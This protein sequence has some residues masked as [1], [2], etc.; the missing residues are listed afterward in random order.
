M[1]LAVML[2]S[3]ADNLGVGRSAVAHIMFDTLSSVARTRLQASVTTDRL[4]IQWIP[5]N[6]A[7]LASVSMPVRAYDHISPVSYFRLLLPD[8]LPADLQRVIYLDCDLAVLGDIGMLWD[9]DLNDHYVAAVPELTTD[10]HLVSSPQGIRLWRELGLAADLEQFNSGVLLINLD[11]W[12]AEFVKQRALIYLEKAADWLRWHDQE[13]LNVVFAGAWLRLDARWNLTMRQLMKSAPVTYQSP[14][15]IHYHSAEKPWH[16]G[17]PFA[18]AD[19]FFDYLDRTAWSGWRPE[20][21]PFAPVRRFFK[22]FVKALHKRQHAFRRLS[23][24]R[25]GRLQGAQLL[26]SPLTLLG[27]PP[28]ANVGPGEIRVFMVAD[29]CTPVACALI[30]HYLASGA[31]RV[32]LAINASVADTWRSFADVNSQVHLVLQGTLSFDEI[33]RVML[34][35]YGQ[36]HWC[37]PA[38][39]NEWL[40]FPCDDQLTL[41][42]LT[43]HLDAQHCTALMSRRVE[44]LDASNAVVEDLTRCGTF[45]VSNEAVHKL[46]MTER[47]MISNRIFVANSYVVP[48]QLESAPYAA[49]RS[50]VSLVKYTSDM[51]IGPNFR[52]AQGIHV[53]DIEGVMLQG[54]TGAPSRIHWRALESAGLLRASEP[55]ARIAML[56][57]PPP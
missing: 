23:N 12:R 8:L 51:L 24:E 11:K 57:T 48:N 9:I 25:A 32:V 19:V 52:S 26:A 56:E 30:E 43:R 4:H 10:S 6:H 13:A 44:L 2:R 54:Q 40:R 33:L 17:Y 50:V 28:P 27:R 36:G 42:A 20:Y 7:G 16:A 31:D 5:V 49:F 37:L 39:P 14:C 22:R 38:R 47:D 53:S 15:I 46:P 29:D 35:N 45:W 3:L 21:L 34:H 1:P 18:L 41:T 55:L